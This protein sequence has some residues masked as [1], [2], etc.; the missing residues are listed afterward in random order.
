MIKI[1]HTADI[2]LGATFKHLGDFGST[3]RS[4]V[5]DSLSR[6]VQLAI[7]EKVDLV[8]I[9]GDLFDSNSVSVSLREFAMAQLKRLSPIPVCILP[10]THDCL[11]DGS[12]YNRQQ[13]TCSGS[14]IH[15][16]KQKSPETRI[17]DRL[18]LAVHGNANLSNQGQESPLQGLKPSE[19]VS[20]NIALAHGSIKIEGKYNPNDFPIDLREIENSGMDYIAL[21]H[22]HRHIDFS[23][24]KT[25]A[26]YSG[27]PETMQ[28][29]DGGD[30][31]FVLI[32]ILG[33]G[34]TRVEKRRIGQYSWELLN[35]DPS[36][37]PSNE[38]I[39]QLLN[40]YSGTNKVLRVAFQGLIS[41]DYDLDFDKIQDDLKGNF[42]FLEIQTD[43]IH[44]ATLEN[45]ETVF[46]KNTIGYNFVKLLQ[47]EIEQTIITRKT[48]LEE[49]LCRGVA[50]LLGRIDPRP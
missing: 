16:F 35:L 45:V 38:R 36:L 27:S 11:E 42:A 4:A 8:L 13:F 34:P 44:S 50:L 10:G 43:A 3:I 39:F 37:Y 6:I 29:E 46:P 32:V 1:L 49:A 20:F 23:S 33:D 48:I 17:F 19:E 7:S 31:G 15:I 2:H 26:F 28:F 14:D 47:K 30:S 12:I 5:K 41:P 21:G 22:W 18:S 25:K 24:N 9:A 40:T